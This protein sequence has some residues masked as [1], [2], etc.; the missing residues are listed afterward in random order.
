[1]LE[2]ELSYEEYIEVLEAIDVAAQMV[3]RLEARPASAKRDVA[4]AVLRREL[5]RAVAD[6]TRLPSASH[7]N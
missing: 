4:L 5:A 6:L 3:D 2:Q 1:V 7:R